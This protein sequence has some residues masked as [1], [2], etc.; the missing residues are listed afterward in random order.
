MAFYLTD[1]LTTRQQSSFR[2]TSGRDSQESASVVVV[3]WAGQSGAWPSHQ[4]LRADPGTM[5]DASQVTDLDPGAVLSNVQVTDGHILV[6]KEN[7]MRCFLSASI[8]FTG[9]ESSGSS[10]SW[11]KL[12]SLTGSETELLTRRIRE[13]CR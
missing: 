13:I 8:L 2:Q 6:W 3:P 4:L 11:D 1:T 12:P 7:F 9:I 10:L 5:N